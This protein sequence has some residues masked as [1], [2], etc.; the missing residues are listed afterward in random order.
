MIDRTPFNPLQAQQVA[1]AFHAAD[2]EYLFIGNGGAILLGYPGTIDRNS[3]SQ[4]RGR[5]HD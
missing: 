1:E 4:R 2:A 3:L 5:A